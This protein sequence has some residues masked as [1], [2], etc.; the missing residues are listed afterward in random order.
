[1]AILFE[2]KKDLV[3]DVRLDRAKVIAVAAVN[4]ALGEE[5]VQPPLQN[6][7]LFIVFSFFTL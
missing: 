2:G 1:M 3:D 7:R 4:A 6:D 5:A